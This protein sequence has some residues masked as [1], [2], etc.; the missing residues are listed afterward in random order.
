LLARALARR[1]EMGIRLA[2]GSSR[3]RLMRQLLVENLLLAAAGGV[4]GLIAGQWA[5]R[6]LIRMIPD[7]L[8]RWAAFQVDAR[9]MA[10]SLVVV[11]LTVLLFGWAPALHALGGDVRSAVHASTNASTGAPRGRRTLWFLVGGEFALAAMLLVCGTLL[12]KAFDRYSTSIR[13]SGP[14]TC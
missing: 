5:T 14:I 4:I 3:I 9:V 12:V 8:P 6:L 2:L 7:E 1:K 11:L 10:F 13:D